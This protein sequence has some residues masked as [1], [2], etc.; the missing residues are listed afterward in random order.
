MEPAFCPPA[1]ARSPF[2]AFCPFSA[3]SPFAPFSPFSAFCDASPWLPFSFPFASG[4]DGDG[5][6]VGGAGSEGVEGGCGGCG[7]EGTFVDEEVAH[8]ANAR[9]SAPETGQCSRGGDGALMG[10]SAP[11]DATSL[12][13]PAPRS[14]GKVLAGTLPAVDRTGKNAYRPWVCP[15]GSAQDVIGPSVEPTHDR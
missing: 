7:R 8:P 3:F 12:A 15:F 11:S 5:D 14:S 10:T 9:M 13:S 4:W 1:S 2:S 6:V